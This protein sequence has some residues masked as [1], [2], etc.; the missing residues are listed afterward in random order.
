VNISHA[1]PTPPTTNPCGSGGTYYSHPA[2]DLNLRHPVVNPPEW[3]NQV[4][5]HD[6]WAYY[7]HKCLTASHGYGSQWWTW[8]LLLR[9]VAYYYQDNLGF[10]SLKHEP[11]RAEVFNLGNPAI[12]WF[13]IPCMVYCAVVAYRERRYAPAF[14]VLAFASAWLPFSGVPRVMFLYHMFGS[15]SFMMLAVAY[16]LARLR[17]SFVLGLDFA[18]LRLPALTGKHLALAYLGLVLLTFAYFY[19]L[20]TGAYLTGDSWTHRMWF[21]V[22]DFLVTKISWI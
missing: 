16:A 9:P 15:L 13:A 20:W 18:G 19:P 12:W 21:Q 7:Y 11:L 14:I 1:I 17:R 4:Y 8:P 5:L 2:L 6:R 22:P 3:V 10:D